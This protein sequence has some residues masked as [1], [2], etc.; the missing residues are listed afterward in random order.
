MENQKELLEHI[1]L[2]LRENQRVVKELAE[3]VNKN[4]GFSARSLTT[5]GDR[6]LENIEKIAQ[7]PSPN[8][9]LPGL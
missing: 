4:D 9:N 1:V 5:R 7:I 2:Y 3:K 6:L 8:P